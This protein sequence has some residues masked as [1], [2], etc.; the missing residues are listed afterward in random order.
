MFLDGGL[1]TKQTVARTED[2]TWLNRFGNLGTF[3][4]NDI[5]LIKR[6]KRSKTAVIMGF[7]FLFYGLLVFYRGNRSL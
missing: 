4:K 7:M 5:K 6:N 1:A 2:Y 3:L